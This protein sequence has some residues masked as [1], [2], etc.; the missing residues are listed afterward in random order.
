MNRLWV[1]LTVAFM[2]ITLLTVGTVAWLADRRADAEFRS[3]LLQPGSPARNKIVDQLADY[4]AA[5]QSWDGV[6]DFAET[7]ITPMRRR[8]RIFG[9]FM[10]GGALPLLANSQGTIIFDSAGKRTEGALSAAERQSAQPIVVNGETVGYLVLPAGMQM[11][12]GQAEV[13]FLT[14]LRRWLTLATVGVGLLGVLLGLA[15]SRTLAS[16]LAALA[17][18]ANGLAKRDWS[19]RVRLESGSSISE[20]AEVANAFNQMAESLEQAEIQRRNLVADVAHELRT[21]ITVLQGNLRAML[22]GVYPLEMNEVATLY[23][24][25]RLLSRMVDDLRELALVEAG[26]LSMAMQAVDPAALLKTAASKF[27][28]AA[29][30]QQI[31][32]AINLTDALPAVKADPDR[33][34][35]VLQNLVTNALRHTPAGGTISVSA[36][37]QGEQ[38]CISVR[39][40][41]EGISA[42]DANHIFE[43]F[44]RADKSRARRSGGS[45]LGLTI[46]RTLVETMGGQIGVESNPEQGSRFWFTLPRSDDKVTG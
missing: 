38:V 10:A 18:A 30:A 4:Y 44:Y 15:V 19:Q 3:Y 17:S 40:S 27:A 46:A 37:P 29:E 14:Q 33:A 35:Q 7:L 2:L 32:F 16:P 5:Q 23:D 36:Q 26:Q 45:G 28:P 20:I 41:G 31:T 12:L 11:M 42:E 34:M 8:Q 6:G 39:D 25:T 13:T 43:R 24:E 21:P 22:D 9:S 1:R